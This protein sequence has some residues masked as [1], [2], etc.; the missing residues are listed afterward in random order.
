M[1]LKTYLNKLNETD[2]VSIG[3]KNGG[4]YVYIG[5]AGNVEQILKEFES[6]RDKVTA[7]LEADRKM[8]SDLAKE[9]PVAGDVHLYAKGLAALYSIIEKRVKYLKG[10]VDP[11]KRDV[12]D[13]G[14]RICDDGVRIIISGDEKGDFWFKDEYDKRRG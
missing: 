10:Y 14:T 1:K 8:E 11:F 12:H 13:E 6:Y 3:T 5:E 2:I 7:K 4:G 9:T